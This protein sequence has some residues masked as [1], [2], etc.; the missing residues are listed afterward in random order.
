MAASPTLIA[1]LAAGSMV[2]STSL[3]AAPAQ[4]QQPCT[5]GLPVHTIAT[6][7]TDYICTLGGVTY[8]FNDTLNELDNPQAV[9]NFENT[10]T[11]QKI[12]FDNL[13]YDGVAV[14][15]YEI[16]S[17]TDSLLGADL[18][19]TQDPATPL[20]LPGTGIFPSPV[21]PQP[22]SASPMQLFTVFEPDASTSP[23]PKL[24]SLTYTIAKTPTPLP[25][26][27]A[28]FAF[29]FSRQLRRRIQRTS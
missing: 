22:P 25:I 21:F 29:G 8:L 23:V 15:Y 12:I 13:S 10:P 7:G 9:V 26:L 24:T 4:A 1:L 27:G 16:F 3:L 19:H 2:L 18:T 11:A 17:P 20:P 5:S 6:L 28:G 14:F